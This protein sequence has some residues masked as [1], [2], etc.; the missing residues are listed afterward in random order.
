MAAM[1]S[2]QRVMTGLRAPR[3]MPVLPRVVK[4]AAAPLRVSSRLRERRGREAPGAQRV[5]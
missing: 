3:S 5:E 2:Q 1:L 4:G